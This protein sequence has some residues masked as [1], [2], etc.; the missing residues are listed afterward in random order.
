MAIDNVTLRAAK[1]YADSL[2]LEG[3]TPI[4]GPPGKDGA[5]LW[6]TETTLPA[7]AGAM[8]SVLILQQGNAYPKVGDLVFHPNNVISKITNVNAPDSQYPY[9]AAVQFLFSMAGSPGAQGLEGLNIFLTASQINTSTNGS[10]ASVNPTAITG[11]TVK[12]GDVILSSHANSNGY[13]GRVSAVSSQTNVTVITAG[14][15]RGVGVAGARGV[16]WWISAAEIE[17]PGNSG[18]IQASALQAQGSLTP[19]V[20]DLVFSTMDDMG[21]YGYIESI[22]GNWIHVH[23][24]G[25]LKGP[26]G[27][28]VSFPAPGAAAVYAGRNAPNGNPLYLKT[29]QGTMPAGDTADTNILLESGN[30]ADGPGKGDIYAVYGWVKIWT[31]TVGWQ[32]VTIPCHNMD[33][34]VWVARFYGGGLY[35]ERRG[36]I[37]RLDYYLTVEFTK[38][39]I[40]GVGVGT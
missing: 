22:Q 7:S 3:A 6:R 39:T 29:Y 5:P 40:A 9:A 32:I 30:N 33:T 21:F 35:L 16:T 25:E 38:T 19:Q 17:P 36:S 20:N 23:T 28:M 15:L 27:N 12:I 1:N 14:S 31:T 2:A 11:R 26:P 24:L 10:Q 4:P 13:Y 8:G 18:A 37:S 34:R